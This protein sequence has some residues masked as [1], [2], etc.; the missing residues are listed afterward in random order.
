MLANVTVIP[1]H[2]FTGSSPLY[3]SYN[4]YIKHTFWYQIY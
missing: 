1:H 2:S 4:V 3:L